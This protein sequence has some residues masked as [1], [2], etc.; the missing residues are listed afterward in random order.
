MHG[1]CLASIKQNQLLRVVFY[2]NI[3]YSTVTCMK[4]SVWSG[5]LSAPPKGSHKGNK[6]ALL[7]I[8]AEG[9]GCCIEILGSTIRVL[10]RGQQV[11]S[12]I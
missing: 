8:F 10:N 7:W 5:I 6:A 1:K 3:L 4:V 9:G 11:T 2:Q 12:D